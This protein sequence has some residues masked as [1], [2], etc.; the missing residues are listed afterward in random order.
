MTIGR[1]VDVSSAQHNDQPP[2]VGP[3]IDWASAK[4][5]GVTTA[6]VKA[7]EGT[8]YLNPW[9]HIDASGAKAAGLD[10]L[11]YHFARMNNPVVEATWFMANAGPLAA[12][13]DYETN[14]NVPW[15]RTFLQALGRPWDQCV[16]YGS[17]SSFG[18]FYQQLPVLSLGCRLRPGLPRLGGHVA[19]HLERGH[20]W[21]PDRGGRV[22]VARQP[23]P[24]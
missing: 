17:A 16:T 18:S 5:N 7:T 19:V 6:L 9:F 11:A 1:I 22:V 23:D 13:L 4:N 10:V 2:G 20:F 12:V 24:V 21:H 3:A 8:G 14:N 15:A